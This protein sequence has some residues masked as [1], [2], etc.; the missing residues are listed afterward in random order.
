MFAIELAEVSVST[1]LPVALATGTATFV[2]RLF[3]GPE[4]AFAVPP[5]DVLPTDFSTALILVLYAVLGAVMGVAATLFIRT[6]HW[7]ED[8]S[9]RIPGRYAR[10][11][12]GMACGS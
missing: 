11:A 5:L 7:A 10:H 8:I 2:G 6:L 12:F 1:F 3:F 4:P 9:D